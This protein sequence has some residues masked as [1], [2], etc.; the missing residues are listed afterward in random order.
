[1]ATKQEILSKLAASHEQRISK[2]LFDLEEDIIAQL[3]RATDGVPLTTDLA[4]QLRPNLKRLIE[5]NYLKEGTKIISEYDEVVKG[6]MDYIRSVPDNLVSPKFK[7][8]TKPDLKLI[9]QLKQLSFSGFEDVANRFLDTIAT[10]VYSSA[11]TGKP[12]PQVV[13]NIRASINGVYR[14]SNEAAVNR[15]V[16]IVEE[17]RYSDDPIAKKK[18]L[19]ARKILHSKYA[20][21]IRGENMRKYASQIAHDSIMQFDGQFTKHK[22]QEA[23]IN[24]YKYTGTNITTTREFCRG[25]LN[26]I[27]TEEEWR[28]VFT[29]NWRGKS[30]SDPFTNRG[31]YRCRHS[32]IPYDP[33]WDAIED[34]QAKIQPRA[35]NIKKTSDV[36]LN[37]SSLASP[38]KEDQLKVLSK[39]MVTERIVK[40]VLENSKDKRY[41][42]DANGKDIGFGIPKKFKF[43]DVYLEGLDDRTISAL[44]AIL[45]E[46]DEFAVKFNIP[47]IRQIITQDNWGRKRLPRASMGQ[48]RLYLNPEHLNLDRKLSPVHLREKD[49]AKA[50]L[51]KEEDFPKVKYD[52]TTGLEADSILP[53]N[54]WYYYDDKV[55]QLRST[56]YHE[57]AHH[58]HQQFGF[59][60][61]RT[62]FQD[63]TTYGVWRD[64]KFPLED[65]IS[66]IRKRRYNTGNNAYNGA[67]EWFADNFSFYYMGQKDLVDPKFVK[68]FEEEV[69]EKL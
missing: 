61:G 12:F 7:T 2:V 42:K 43:G 6:Y 31:G 35:T 14:R 19:D 52:R 60:L 15:L 11:I 62:V 28:E 57:F 21:D 54:S 4:I 17:N 51:N 44:E 37:P 63:G 8:L 33:A 26:E 58:V 30:G 50:I 27:K 16:A 45:D 20:S 36:N 22:G 65:K 59:K 69:L 53:Y 3:Q 23:G 46:L 48:G 5:E 64:M 34:V 68:F 25:Q 32:L 41:P 10:E 49:K 1:M 56:L 24:T 47:K 9:N 67:V 38:I 66:K 40:R 39:G 29:R 55:D 18:Y 13:E